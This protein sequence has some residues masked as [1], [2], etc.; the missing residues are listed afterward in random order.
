VATVR[1]TQ[2][3]KSDIAREHAARAVRESGGRMTFPTRAV[4]AILG[5]SDDHLTADDII[6]EL[7][8][9]S[10]GIAPSTVYRVI[11]RLGELDVIAHVHTGI[12]PAVYHLRATS[13]AHLVC[14]RCHVISDVSER[15]LGALAR[16]LRRQHGFVLDAHHSALIG[17]CANCAAEPVAPTT[18]DE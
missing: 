13:H 6:A 3:E 7:E 12:G 18:P 15:E 1:I 8:R 17:L 9:R 11:Q 16:S 5:E 4:L 14:N 10:P 2:I